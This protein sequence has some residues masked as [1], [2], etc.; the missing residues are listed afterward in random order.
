MK[1]LHVAIV[2]HK[3]S[4][5]LESSKRN[6]RVEKQPHVSESPSRHKA[7]LPEFSRRSQDKDLP[8]EM[9]GGRK[10]M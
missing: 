1:R 6:S 9:L 4:V 2:S 7:V 10:V 5:S 3:I 8:P